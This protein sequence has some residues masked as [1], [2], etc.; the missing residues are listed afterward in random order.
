MAEVTK[1][2]HKD[3]KFKQQQVAGAQRALLEELF[4]D[5]YRYRWK[6]YQMNFVR[7]I[8]FGFGSVI[9]ATVV[10]ALA[11][12]LLSPFMDIPFLGGLFEKTQSTIQKNQ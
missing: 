2:Q 9:G 11:I 8:F 5:Q 7:G 10:V 12:S 4:N 6:V 1:K 3:S